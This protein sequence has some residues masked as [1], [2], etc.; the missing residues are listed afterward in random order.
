MSNISK[1]LPARA[2]F[3]TFAFMKKLIPGMPGRASHFFKSILVIGFLFGFSQ[4]GFAQTRYVQTYKPYADSL[5]AEYGIPAAVMLGVAILESGSGT[6]RNAKLLN[7]HFGIVGKNKLTTVKSRYKQYEHPRE[8]Y[9]DFCKLVKKKK[10]YEKL[11]GNTNPTL[12]IEALSKVGYSEV[13]ETWKSRVLSTIKK[14]KLA[15][16]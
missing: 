13:P 12:W 5:S 4:A 16:P 1:G 2:G 11:K 8:S 7:N 3:F 9:K 15:S 14:N 6:S 10:F